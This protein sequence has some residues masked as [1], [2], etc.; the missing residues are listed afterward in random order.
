M[1]KGFK[2]GSSKSRSE[3]DKNVVNSNNL[4]IY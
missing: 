1:K 2:L 3:E 4:T